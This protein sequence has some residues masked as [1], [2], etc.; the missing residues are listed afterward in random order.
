MVYWDDI[1]QDQACEISIHLY[2]S[3]SDDISGS[4]LRTLNPNGVK[5]YRL[6]S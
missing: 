3:L 6:N 4:F 1:D 2:S 5:L